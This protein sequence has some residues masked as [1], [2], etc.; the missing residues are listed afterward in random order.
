MFVGH[1]NIFA[2][3]IDCFFSF[4]KSFPL[5]WM[6]Q[7]YFSFYYWWTLKVL[8][9]IYLLYFPSCHLSLPA[10]VKILSLANVS[11]AWTP[12]MR[13]SSPVE[14]FWWYWGTWHCYMQTQSKDVEK[15]MLLEQLS[16]HRKWKLISNCHSFLVFLK[17][18]S[19]LLCI[20]LRGVWKIAL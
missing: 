7:T 9:S 16:I 8:S 4:L 5:M 13:I 12:K 2:S 1:I 15:C 14:D 11:S 19:E 17:D 3:S 20:H 6:F 10:P 18:N